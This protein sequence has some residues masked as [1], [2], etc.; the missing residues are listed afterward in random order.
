MGLGLGYRLGVGACIG[1]NVDGNKEPGTLQ[2]RIIQSDARERH[3]LGPGVEDK[4]FTKADISALCHS[5]VPS[6]AP[7]KNTKGSD[8]WRERLKRLHFLL[9]YLRVDLSDV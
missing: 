8:D 5:F 4:S 1:V 2:S 3:S 6:S 9:V 7:A